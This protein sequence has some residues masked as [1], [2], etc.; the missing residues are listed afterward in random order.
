MFETMMPYIH[1]IPLWPG[2]HHD[3]QLETVSHYIGLPYD[4]IEKQR[5]ISD[6]HN[7]ARKLFLEKYGYNIDNVDNVDNENIPYDPSKPRISTPAYIPKE[8]KIKP[9]NLESNRNARMFLNNNNLD[10][11]QGSTNNK[12]II[13]IMAHGNYC[14][15]KKYRETQLKEGNEEVKNRLLLEKYS[16]ESVPEDLKGPNVQLLSTQTIGRYAI[17]EFYEVFYNL[18]KK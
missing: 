1:R 12:Q 18:L 2:L 8:P 17:T 13:I 7:H 10:L 4:E 15:Y 3:Y 9:A 16:A 11:P 5:L 14:E 6:A